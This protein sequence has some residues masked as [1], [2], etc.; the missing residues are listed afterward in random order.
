V[1]VV[2]AALAIAIYASASVFTLVIVAWSALACSIGPLV[3][4]QALGQRLTQ[5]VAL[6]MMAAGLGVALL[7]R[8]TGLNAAVYEGLPGLAAAFFVWI[9]ASVPAWLGT[10]ASQRQPG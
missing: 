8:W 3:I 10:G 2:F 1:L 7:W 6:A 9:A 5:P 4:L